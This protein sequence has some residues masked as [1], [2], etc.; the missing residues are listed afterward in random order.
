MFIKI[1]NSALLLFAAY[2]GLKQGYA[3]LC[4]KPVMLELFGKWNFSKTAI[5]INGGITMFSA[6][7]ILYPKTFIWGNFL[8]AATILLIV[9]FQLFH[10]DLKGAVTE[11]PFFLLNL[12]IIFLQHPLTS[13]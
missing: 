5:L 13:I 9:C 10:Q 1:F 8:M 6:L 7:L 12:L 2:M 3:M 11:L 4:L